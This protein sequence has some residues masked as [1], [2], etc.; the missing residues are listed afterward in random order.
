MDVSKLLIMQ[1]LRTHLNIETLS[2]HS[3]NFLQLDIDL[4]I[5]FCKHINIQVM[6]G[7]VESAQYKCASLI[8]LDPKNDGISW[9]CV[10]NGCLNAATIQD[11]YLLQGKT[12]LFESLVKVKAY[13][14]VITLRE[15]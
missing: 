3:Q 13:T 1:N 7:I 6:A 5:C 15:W 10:K 8:V 9:I 14:A 11:T 4:D 2:I 12:D